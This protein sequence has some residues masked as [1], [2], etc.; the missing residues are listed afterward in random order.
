MTL[1]CDTIKTRVDAPI[2]IIG[3]LRSPLLSFTSELQIDAV[4]YISTSRTT[5]GST[6][7]RDALSAS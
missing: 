3:I 6:V 2:T 1:Y 7:C 4:A 5:I